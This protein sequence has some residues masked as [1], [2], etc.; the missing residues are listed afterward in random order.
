MNP[1]ISNSQFDNAGSQQAP[2]PF[3]RPAGASQTLKL[4]ARVLVV[5]LV[6][7]ARARRYVLR[8]NN[9]GTLRLT[10][11]RWGSLAAARRFARGE[12]RWIERERARLLR[13]A[14]P[15]VPPAERAAL[16]RRAL[17]E[18]PARLRRLAAAHGFEAGRVT[19]RDQRSRWGSC[20]PNGDISLNWRLITMP[21]AVRDY[22]LLHELAH[23]REPNHSR[24]FWRLVSQICPGWRD[25]R[26][27]L[28]EHA[29]A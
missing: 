4:G 1:A 6:R 16:K 20:S 21:A 8:V 5:H 10:L 25:A 3:G 13:R 28:R 9:D 27:W 29:G 23:L 17:V 7:D 2:L 22:V 15:L 18:L 14:A 11:P 12:R 19:I 24:R 26:Q